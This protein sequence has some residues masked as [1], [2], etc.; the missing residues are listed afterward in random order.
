[1]AFRWNVCN[2]FSFIPK[3]YLTWDGILT[4]W[5]YNI[6]ENLRLENFI[7]N[8]I[9]KNWNC[10]KPGIIVF[11]LW[12]VRKMCGII[13]LVVMLPFVEINWVIWISN[14]YSRISS[15]LVFLEKQ[16]VFFSLSSHFGMAANELILKRQ[17]QAIDFRFVWAQNWNLS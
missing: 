4:R 8:N 3:R 2:D 14:F 10:R 11:R 1:M 7:K 5:N 13:F 15:R 12:G 9:N 6:S 17:F 16:I